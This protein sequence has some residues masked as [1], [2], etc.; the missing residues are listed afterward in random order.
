[1]LLI[2]CTRGKERRTSITNSSRGFSSVEKGGEKASVA[3]LSSGRNGKAGGGV[4]GGAPVL[5]FANRIYP[6]TVTG[7]P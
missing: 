4:S 7:K 1:V 5:Y 3:N 6:G 2:I